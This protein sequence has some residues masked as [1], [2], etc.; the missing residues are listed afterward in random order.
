[1]RKQL[2]K[3]KAEALAKIKNDNV[4]TSSDEFA[5]PKR[6]TY[7]G[8]FSL[9]LMTQ[10][11]HPS[12]ATTPLHPSPSHHQ[13]HQLQ[14]QVPSLQQV[15]RSQQMVTQLAPPQQSSHPRHPPP[16]MAIPQQM[17]PPQ[18]QQQFQQ[19]YPPPPPPQPTFQ[20]YQ[21]MQQQQQ[22]QQFH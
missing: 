20:R 21:L 22:Q 12:T 14:H 13:H 6:E 9:P 8:E 5:S 1:M 7:H 2:R 3:T 15:A 10:H 19:N 17:V 11:Q 18:Q 16:Q 4:T